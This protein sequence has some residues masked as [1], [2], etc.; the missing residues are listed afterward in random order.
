MH[1]GNLGGGRYQVYI[2]G[3]ALAR[4]AGGNAINLFPGPSAEVVAD[5]QHL[6]NLVDMGFDKDLA[7]STLR[8]TR[9]DFE[10]AL[11]Q[12]I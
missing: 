8:Q 1:L 6:Q 3:P 9:N 7:A 10:N 4:H 11:E 12:L 2:G 5:E